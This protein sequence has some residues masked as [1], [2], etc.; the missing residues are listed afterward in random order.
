MTKVI[1]KPKYMMFDDI[2]SFVINGRSYAVG[3]SHPRRQEI[4]ELIEDPS[5]DFTDEEC[6]KLVNFF[7]EIIQGLTA[8]SSHVEKLPTGFSYRGKPVHQNLLRLIVAET[9]KANPQYSPYLKFLDNLE[10][11]PSEKAREA[12]YSWMS[13]F[14]NESNADSFP[15]THDGKMVMYRNLSRLPRTKALASDLRGDILVDGEQLGHGVEIYPG[16]IIRKG[17]LLKELMAGKSPEYTETYASVFWVEINPK[18]FTHFDHNFGLAYAT[19]FQIGELVT[20][21]NGSPMDNG[22]WAGWSDNELDRWNELGLPAGD[23]ENFENEWITFELALRL[24][25]RL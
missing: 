22:L 3:K 15:I 21:F 17:P 25:G 1:N 5:Y 20:D 10:A 4:I 11:N 23:I 16:S 9:K 19:K 13:N 2:I 8:I 12:L 14:P 6:L 18:D 24:K 7:D